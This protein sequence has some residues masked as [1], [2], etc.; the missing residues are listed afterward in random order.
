MW[1]PMYHLFYIDIVFTGK[2]LSHRLNYHSRSIYIS[3]S[4][5]QINRGQC[6][7]NSKYRK[8]FPREICK[9]DKQMLHSMRLFIKFVNL[10][11]NISCIS[12]SVCIKLYIT[13]HKKDV[14]SLDS[15][16]ALSNVLRRYVLYTC[17]TA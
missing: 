7:L 12:N 10:K 11:G 6:T 5:V 3:T 1:V 16:F 13:Y 15:V 4:Q 8:Y 9:S 17:R 14:F 2:R